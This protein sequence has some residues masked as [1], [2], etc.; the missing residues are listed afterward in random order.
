MC[1]RARVHVLTDLTVVCLFV[2]LPVRALSSHCVLSVRDDVGP[3]VLNDVVI[4][5]SIRG[6]CLSGTWHLGLG[7]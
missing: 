3:I 6:Q 4:I 2:C 7:K 1:V 5:L